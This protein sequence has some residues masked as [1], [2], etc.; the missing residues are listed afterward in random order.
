MI[1]L[2]TYLPLIAA[3]AVVSGWTAL[4]QDAAAVEPVGE[5]HAALLMTQALPPGHPPIDGA[6]PGLPEGHP[7]VGSG[8]LSLPPGHPPVCPARGRIPGHDLPG[9]AASPHPDRPPLVST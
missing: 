1:R 7:P 4:R 8:E 9:R 5:A 6:A 2:P 3:V